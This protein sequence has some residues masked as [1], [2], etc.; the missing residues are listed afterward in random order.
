MKPLIIQNA[1][2]GEQNKFL[3]GYIQNLWYN[4]DKH[5]LTIGMK[6]ADGGDTEYANIMVFEYCGSGEHRYPNPN[7]LLVQDAYEKGV[8]I[9]CV[10]LQQ[11]Q[12]KVLK[13]MYVNFSAQQDAPYDI[14]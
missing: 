13:G 14:L 10:Y 2:R 1:K 3:G 6:A 12:S 5:Y 9:A 7:Y 4:Y 11:S 8:P